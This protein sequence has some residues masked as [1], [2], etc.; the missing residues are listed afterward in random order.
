MDNK[1]KIILLFVGLGIITVLLIILF[2]PNIKKTFN[3]ANPYQPGQTSQNGTDSAGGVLLDAS[4]VVTS[5]ALQNAKVEA[6]GANPITADNQVVTVEGKKTLNN[7][8][9]TSPQ[10]PSQTAPLKAESLSA[11]V[12][13]VSIGN[14]AFNPDSF[15]VN[16]GSPTTIALT[17]VDSYAHSFVFDDSSLSAIGLGVYSKET[18]AVTFN[19]P[20]KPGEYTFRCN[21]GGHAGRGEIG[22]M[23]VK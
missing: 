10:A 8:S 19:A 14:G 4:A 22:K 15:S 5:E 17:S 18:R 6:P 20:T 1:Y 16:A 21:V 13:K 23:I 2:A 9:P 7:V 11:N 12:I 3:N